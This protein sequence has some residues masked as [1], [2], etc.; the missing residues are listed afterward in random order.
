MKTAARLTA[1]VACAAV[2]A[3]L[4]VAAPSPAQ[5]YSIPANING[6]RISWDSSGHLYQCYDGPETD[7]D[8]MVDVNALPTYNAPS[9]GNYA[10]QVFL[11]TTGG[12][13]IR[14]IPLRYYSLSGPAY[15]QFWSAAWKASY[16]YS[17]EAFVSAYVFK[18]IGSTYSVV[19]RESFGCR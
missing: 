2:S 16:R 7:A 17:G 3:G 15:I 6:S 18:Q 14:Y 1:F 4:V 11:M 8:G 5:A 9:A 13:T 12:S 19:A 10:V